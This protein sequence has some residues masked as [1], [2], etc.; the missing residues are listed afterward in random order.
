LEQVTGLDEYQGL[1]ARRD[2]VL[3]ELEFSRE[4]LDYATA[5]GDEDLS[6]LSNLNDE[7]VQFEAEL[8]NSAP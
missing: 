3:A 6:A 4:L 2:L 8:S 5:K 7:I 1:S